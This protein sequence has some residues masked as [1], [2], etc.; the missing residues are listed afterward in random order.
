MAY[1][2]QESLFAGLILG[3]ILG[4]YGNFLVSA[5]FSIVVDKKNLP[6]MTIASLIVI[7]IGFF[8]FIGIAFAYIV[9]T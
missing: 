7:A 5:Y 2:P 1:T 9:F 3:S 6:N 8:L 4:V